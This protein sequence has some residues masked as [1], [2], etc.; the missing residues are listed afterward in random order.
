MLIQQLGGCASE[1]RLP[2]QHL[3][4]C[5]AQRVEVRADVDLHSRELLGTGKIRGPDKAPRHGNGGLRTWFIDRLGQAE[6]DYFRCHRASILQAHYDVARFDVPVDE[7]L[8]VHRSQT[9][10]DLRRDFECQLYPEPT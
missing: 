2:S 8:F 6:V 10:G 3:P 4:K 1:W 9:D 5:R 7:V